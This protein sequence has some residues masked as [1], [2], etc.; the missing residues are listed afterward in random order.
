VRLAVLPLYRDSHYTFRFAGDRIVPRFHLEGVEIGRRV[1]VFKLDPV[2][3]DRLGLLTT[4]VAD[5]GGWV[6]LTEPLVVR[7]G[8]GFIAVPEQVESHL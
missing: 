4:G 6:E 1:T 3:G 5:D 8:E 2:T 7:A